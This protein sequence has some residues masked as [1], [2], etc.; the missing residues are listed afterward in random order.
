[1]RAPISSLFTPQFVKFCVVGGLG[2][3]TDQTIFFFLSR[4]VDP[5]SLFVNLVWIV[6][7][8]L[9]VIQNYL[10]NHYWTF[11]SETR[12][13]H[14]SGKG[15]LSFFVISVTAL[16]PRFLA[17]KGVIL[18]LGTSHLILNM[19]NLCGIAAGTVVN[20]W[21]S[22]FIVFREKKRALL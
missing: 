14:A 2:L 17:Y 1:M 5:G 18:A 10:I 11:K 19:A 15:L 12:D 21:G 9:A 3:V 7:Y 8:A 16:I 4:V 20:F 6:G 13:T 22:K